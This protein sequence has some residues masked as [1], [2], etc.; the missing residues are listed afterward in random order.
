M[1]LSGYSPIITT[2]SVRNTQLLKSL[3]ASHVL[4]RNLPASSLSA[5]VAEIT[6]KPILLV[7]DAASTPE[8][9]NL[10][11][12]LLSAGGTLVTVLPIFI[13]ENKLTPDK[14]VTFI[15]GVPFLPDRRALAV[16]MYKHLSAMFERGELKVSFVQSQN[17]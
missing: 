3:G 16:E 9:E 12:D 6:K 11:Y 8:T 13:P 5:A 4:D 7:Y 10:G 2:A 1:K 14:R 15:E 17:E